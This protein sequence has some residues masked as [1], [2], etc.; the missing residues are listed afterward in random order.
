[1][2]SP[3]NAA[4]VYSGPSRAKCE[5]LISHGADPKQF[6]DHPNYHVRRKAWTKL[7]KTPRYAKFM[8]GRK[9]KA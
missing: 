4:P 2:A 1:M 8:A 9:L 3:K 7:G 6:L 5:H